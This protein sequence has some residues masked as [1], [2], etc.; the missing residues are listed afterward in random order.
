MASAC[1]RAEH[2]GTSFNKY[3]ANYGTVL[4]THT[5]T[6][7]HTQLLAGSS[8]A[9]VPQT[10]PPVPSSSFS[11]NPPPPTTPSGSSAGWAGKKRARTFD[12]DDNTKRRRT[13]PYSARQAG[14]KQHNKG[15]RHFSQRVCEKVREKGTTTYNEV[16]CYL[17]VCVSPSR[18][19][20]V[21]YMYFTLDRG[22]FSQL[23][24][25]DQKLLLMFCL[26]G[27]RSPGLI[28]TLTS[29]F[30]VYSSW[31]VDS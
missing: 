23:A 26:S 6:H 25:E 7:T 5:H 2:S 22:G 30:A 24:T 12:L 14:E 31:K 4:S 28:P 29:T 1:I 17:S 20:A 18:P 11:S 10:K 15:L 3:N 13:T 16:G 8:S 21:F 9:R 19:P 27:T